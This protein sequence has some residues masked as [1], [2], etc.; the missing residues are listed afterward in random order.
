VSTT[1]SRVSFAVYLLL[2]IDGDLLYDTS[3]PCGRRAPP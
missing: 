3:K 1:S 2:Q